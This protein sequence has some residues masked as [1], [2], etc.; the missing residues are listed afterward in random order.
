MI[1][2]DQWDI[3]TN[4]YKIFTVYKD[5]FNIAKLLLNERKEYNSVL[6][7]MAVS[8]SA[9]KLAEI[10]HAIWAEFGDIEFV[11]GG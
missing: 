7:F 4:E 8:Y 6:T 9:R 1:T 2:F 3:A 11:I 5:G 10:S